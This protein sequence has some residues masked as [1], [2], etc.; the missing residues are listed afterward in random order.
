MRRCAGD[1]GHERRSLSRP[2][3]MAKRTACSSLD[4][5]GRR[6]GK[7]RCRGAGS[8][9]RGRW[10]SRSRAGG[11]DVVSEQRVPCREF[12]S[13]RRSGRRRWTRWRRGWW[14]RR[15][16]YRHRLW[17][18]L[19]AERGL[20]ALVRRGGCG[21]CRDEPRKRGSA[22]RCLQHAGRRGWDLPP[23][24]IQHGARHGDAF[25]DTPM[26]AFAFDMLDYESGADG[27][28]IPW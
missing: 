15:S 7:R 27:E 11:F 16:L 24:L 19:L 9:R 21:C 1:G 25:R 13:Q 8:E 18:A 14:G 3:F 12:G 10:C 22:R 4:L 6:C 20:D 23:P 5:R 17:F 28:T 2:L 26:F